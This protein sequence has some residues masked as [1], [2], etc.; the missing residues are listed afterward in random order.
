MKGR[1]IPPESYQ[2]GA[3]TFGANTLPHYVGAFFEWGCSLMGPSLKEG[4]HKMRT[5][6]YERQKIEL[7]P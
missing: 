2:F 3:P 4:P 7:F 5:Y 1:A 6:F